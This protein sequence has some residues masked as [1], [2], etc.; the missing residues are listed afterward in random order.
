MKTFAY[1]ITKL[2]IILTC[3]AG[4]GA[5]ITVVFAVPIEPESPN[6][7]SIMAIKLV[8]FFLMGLFYRQLVKLK[9]L[10]ELSK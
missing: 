10:P 8:C 2:F 1:N 3:I 5:A 6:Y 7:W 9:V 4:F